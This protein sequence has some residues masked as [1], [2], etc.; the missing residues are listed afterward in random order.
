VERKGWSY[1]GKK[2][3]SVGKS[4]LIKEKE[5]EKPKNY[6]LKNGF[7]RKEKRGN[8]RVCCCDGHGD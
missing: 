1:G 8:Q 2:E 3:N 7:Q 4:Q 6:D 5:G